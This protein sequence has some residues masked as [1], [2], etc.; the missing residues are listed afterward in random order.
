M[1]M[2]RPGGGKISE[3]FVIGM[4]TLGRQ[5]PVQSRSVYFHKTRTKYFK[6]TMPF[7]RDSL[8][9]VKYIS[10]ANIITYTWHNAVRK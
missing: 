3:Q 9:N 1:E 2:G 10:S 6:Y 5:T 4:N 7:N 8:L